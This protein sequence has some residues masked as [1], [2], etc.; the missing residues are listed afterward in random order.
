MRFCVLFGGDYPRV[1]G[2]ERIIYGM[3]SGQSGLPPRGRG[4]GVGRVAYPAPTRITPA[5]AGKSKKIRNLR[6]TSTDYPRVGGEEGASCCRWGCV[7][8]LPPRGRGRGQAR[9]SFGRMRRITPAWAGKRHERVS[10]LGWLKDYPRV[11][12]EETAYMFFAD[13]CS[14]LPPRGRGRDMVRRADF[15]EWGITPAWAGKS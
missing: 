15:P 4:R 5:W 1:G 14:G 6:S 3:K 8:G 9:R 7:M 10:C 13:A 2:E 12:G 11:G